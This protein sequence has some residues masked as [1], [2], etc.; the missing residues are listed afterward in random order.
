MIKS[1]DNAAIK[2]ECNMMYILSKADVDSL[3][4]EKNVVKFQV[5]SVW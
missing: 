3:G 1:A 2:I 4:E 5:W